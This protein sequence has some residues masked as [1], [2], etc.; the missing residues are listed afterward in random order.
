PPWDKRS[1]EPRNQRA[2]ERSGRSLSAYIAESNQRVFVAVLEKIIEVAADF[3]RG[4]CVQ[5]NFDSNDVGNRAWHQHGLK[6]V[7]SQQILLHAPFA[8]GDLL[9]KPGVFHRSS[10][11]GRQQRE[12]AHVIVGKERQPDTLEIENAN[13]AVVEDERNRHF[14]SDIAVSN[15][16]ARVLHYIRDTYD[17]ARLGGG[18]RDSFADLN[19]F[20][21][22]F[23]V[24]T[25]A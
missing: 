3:A 13:H 23:L 15:D 9:V 19:I 11:L 7:S 14:G 12:S 5:A 17:L 25:L 22:G 16:I 8:P 2:I 21:S 18:P 10:N 24:V 20:D 4:P 1:Q 6:L